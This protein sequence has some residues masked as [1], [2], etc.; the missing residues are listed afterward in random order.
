[1][2]LRERSLNVIGLN[3]VERWQAGKRQQ[4][5]GHGATRC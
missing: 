3:L 5:V 2:Q 4:C 1:M